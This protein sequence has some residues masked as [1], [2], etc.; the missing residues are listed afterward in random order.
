MRQDRSNQLRYAESQQRRALKFIGFSCLV[1]FFAVVFWVAIVIGLRA[2]GISWDAYPG[3]SVILIIGFILVAFGGSWYW[4]AG[5]DAKQA[6]Q[7]EISD[8]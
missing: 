2:N 7:T 4:R 6:L 8:Q 3:L 1:L 5:R